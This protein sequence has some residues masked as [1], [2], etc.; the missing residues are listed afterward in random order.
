MVIFLIILFIL[1]LFA[2]LIVS[3]NNIFSPGVITT[4]IWIFCLS[5]FLLLKHNLPPL[6]GQFYCAISLW[7]FLYVFSAMFI[8][9]A[10]FSN[11]F[12]YEPSKLVMDI[13]FLLS[14]CTYPLLLFFAYKAIKL[15]S[16][17]NWAKDLRLAAIGQTKFFTEMLEVPYFLI[18]NASFMI[19]LFFYSK[20]NRHRVFILG[21]FFLSYAFFTMS[22]FCFLDFFLRTICVLYLT[23]RVS[24]KHL[25]IGLSCLFLF[26]I[27]LQSV[28][29]SLD[30]SSSYAKNDFLVLY[31][32]GN[33][34]A[35]CT[36]E[37]F[38]SLHF[39]E[40]TFRVIYAIFYKFG[41]SYIKPVN[42]ILSWINKP[43]STNTYTGMYPFFKDFGYW[44]VGVFATFFGL[45]FGWLFK[46]GQQGNKLF[47]ILY[48]SFVTIIVAQYVGDVFFTGISGHIKAIVLL[49]LP[50]LAT[51]Y[52]WFVLKNN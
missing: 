11:R 31:L 9:T 5:L 41:I 25:L 17:G 20:K 39:G 46:K 36:L 32:V 50:F 42:I 40:N 21:F 49:I 38:S 33:M 48:S 22:K 10:K 16:T 2:S 27:S 30:M 51:K 4:A 3:K 35:F 12:N 18:W 8:Q 14:L 34:S 44:G 13:Y 1:L 52:K 6:T 29:H 43:I 45:L 47:I 37:P 23:K 28:R 7:I 15:G 26:F 24:I 19:E